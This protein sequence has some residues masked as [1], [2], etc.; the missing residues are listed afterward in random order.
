MP[1]GFRRAA[2]AA[3]AALLI[4]AGAAPSWSADLYE[5]PAQQETTPPMFDLLVLRPVGIVS[6]GISALLFI[7]PVAPFTLLTKPSQIGKPFRKMVV[8]PAR[9]VV[10]DPLGK[11]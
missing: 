9:F 7:V 3:C 4:L 5:D 2:A 11:H 8:E 6:A 10:V 1:D